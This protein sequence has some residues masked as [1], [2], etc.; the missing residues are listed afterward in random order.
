MRSL[1]VPKTG[2]LPIS[3]L[4][5]L[6]RL[7]LNVVPVASF[8]KLVKLQL[9]DRPMISLNKII[10]VTG[11]PLCGILCFAPNTVQAAPD[12]LGLEQLLG[13]LSLEEEFQS[14][15][16]TKPEGAPMEAAT[17]PGLECDNR[18]NLKEVKAVGIALSAP[19]D[20][21][22]GNKIVDINHAY[23]NG[24]WNVDDSKSTLPLIRETN[25]WCNNL[26]QQYGDSLRGAAEQAASARCIEKLSNAASNYS[27]RE[28][29]PNI[30]PQNQRLT[31]DSCRK[32]LS[33]SE[34]YICPDAT[35]CHLVP[36]SFKVTVPKLEISKKWTSAGCQVSC[37]L[38][39]DIFISGYLKISAKSVAQG[40]NCVACQYSCESSQ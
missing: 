33:S 1:E 25:S 29:V 12:E 7:L 5:G 16:E 36:D 38:P 3:V 37:D 22:L 32:P 34:S 13:I 4:S 10:L 23:C 26:A 9:G 14:Y 31:N 39:K 20:G 8:R 27:C 15:S 11:L 6:V 30:C 2:L 40:A 35:P 17:L 24:G 19:K 18:W 21:S 28:A